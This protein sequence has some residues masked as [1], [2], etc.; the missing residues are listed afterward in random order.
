MH[1]PF[2]QYDEVLHLTLAHESIGVM[3]LIQTPSLQMKPAEHLT[4]WQG[5][6]KTETH[7]PFLET[8]LKTTFD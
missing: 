5:F 4:V 8:V 3:S 2:S 6:G 1:C 7:L